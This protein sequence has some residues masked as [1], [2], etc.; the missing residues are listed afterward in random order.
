[1][2]PT[3]KRW[4]QR[5]L[6]A[7]LVIIASLLIWIEETLWKWL[8]WL[9]A[10]IAV[11]AWVRRLESLICQLP[12]YATVVVFFLPLTILLPFKLVAVYWLSQ[13][14]WFGSLAVIIL[15]KILGT[16]IEARMFVI[17][18]PKLM[19]IPWFRRLHDV[20]VQIR[21]RL[22]AALHSLAIYQL[23]RARLLAL[24]LA[25]RNLLAKIRLRW[26]SI[27]RWIYR[28]QSPS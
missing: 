27:R 24:K 23:A 28:N 21:D 3:K 5:C 10:K 19:T 6:T 13:G 7:P 12:P 20:V 16:A 22:H 4:W 11:L 15:A 26:Q 2:T 8:K 18:K 14:Y 17:C 1:M 9:M 25:C